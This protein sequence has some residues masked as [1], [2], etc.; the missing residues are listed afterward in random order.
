[1][2]KEQAAAIAAC[3]TWPASLKSGCNRVRTMAG[4]GG[5]TVNLSDEMWVAIVAGVG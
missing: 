4:V 1:M 5:S 3:I 2:G